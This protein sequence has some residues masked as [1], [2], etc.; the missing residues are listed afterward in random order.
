MW[1]ILGI[2]LAVVDHILRIDSFPV[3]GGCAFI[4]ESRRFL[5]GCATN[6]LVAASRL[7]LSASIVSK[8]GKDSD[9]DFIVSE[10]RRRGVDTS[11][12]IVDPMLPSGKVI[13]VV[14]DE[15]ERTFFSLLP[16][17][18][19]SSFS[20]EDI[21]PSVIEE[22]K[23]LFGDGGAF[24]AE[25]PIEAVL[26]AMKIAKR[27]SVKTSLDPN[28]RVP[29]KRLPPKL[30][31]VFEKAIELTDILLLNDEEA[32]MITEEKEIDSAVEHL[33]KLGPEIVALKLGSK[34]CIV[35]SDKEK[36]Y[37]P[38]FK[39]DVVDTIGAGDAYNAGFL[40]GYLK[41]LSL[42]RIGIL[43]NA[44]GGLKTTRKGASSSPTIEEVKSLIRE[45][46]GIEIP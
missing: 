13:A 10:L 35:F 2:G 40:Y 7:G 44:V 42:R 6:L 25:K 34:G 22:A 5:G 17:S 1:D 4:K 8:I 45:K 11:Y 15:G 3:R 30:K 39:V 23:I 9:G 32:L 12:I 38:A 31:T 19:L 18:S 21:D 37:C 27:S 36:I 16:N 20:P 46:A 29:E 26:K 14:D 41:G 24:F 33:L 43:A 28:L